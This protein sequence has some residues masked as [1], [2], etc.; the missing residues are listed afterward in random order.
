MCDCA[1]YGSSEEGKTRTFIFALAAN[2]FVFWT[3][4]GARASN[5]VPT[6]NITQNCETEAAGSG[7]PGGA[8]NCAKDEKDAKS[9]LGKSW[10]RF[11]ASNKRHCVGESEI[12]GD[13][14]YVELLTCLEMSSHNQFSRKK[15]ATA[16]SGL[17]EP[18]R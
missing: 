7:F 14:S 3:F 8:K 16:L 12:G 13:Q 18:P 2:I 17:S 5:G 1:R 10:P 11:S 4:N 15:S 9:Q 6:F